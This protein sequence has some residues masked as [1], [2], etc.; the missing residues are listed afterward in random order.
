[1]WMR[2]AKERA[3]TRVPGCCFGGPGRHMRELRRSGVRETLW[4]SRSAPISTSK[5]AGIP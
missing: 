5:R 3:E 1:M 2:L 4:P